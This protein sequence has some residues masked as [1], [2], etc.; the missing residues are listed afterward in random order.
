MIVWSSTTGW[1]S[2]HANARDGSHRYT[3][4]LHDTAKPICVCLYTAS[5][6]PDTPLTFPTFQPKRGYHVGDTTR[7]LSYKNEVSPRSV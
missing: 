4:H 6:T 5:G 2:V 3:P 1:V 7:R